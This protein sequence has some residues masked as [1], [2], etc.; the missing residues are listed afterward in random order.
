MK[1]LLVFT[2]LKSLLCSLICASQKFF[3]LFTKPNV[4]LEMYV[5]RMYV[6]RGKEALG[7]SHLLADVTVVNVP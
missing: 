7:N 5:E 4:N 6:L 3:R 1:G 2:F